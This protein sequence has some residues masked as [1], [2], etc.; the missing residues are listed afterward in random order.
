[1][2][3]A[4]GVNKFIIFKL[5]FS[6]L[7]TVQA[8]HGQTD[9]RFTQTLV[10]DQNIFRNYQ[11]ADDWIHQSMLLFEQKV[12]TNPLTFR[13]NYAGSLQ[14]FQNYTER[15][16][17]AHQLMGS[18][19]WTLTELLDLNSGLNFDWF[20]NRETYKIYDFTSLSFFS[21]LGI[22]FQQNLPVEIG[23]E[24]ENQNY[25]ALTQFSCL[26]QIGLMRLK[27]FL[28]TKTTFIGELNFNSK[29]YKNALE[30]D[31]FEFEHPGRRNRYGQS[32]GNGGSKWI[33]DSDSLMT[34][35]NLSV[36]NSTQWRLSVRLA[37]SIG[38]KTG[39]S[40]V[41]SHQFKPSNAARYLKEQIYSFSL[42]NS[43][44]DD[45][46]TYESTGYQIQIS[47]LLPAGSSLKVYYDFADK[48]YAYPTT[49]PLIIKNNNRH[50]TQESIHLD[51]KI[52]LFRTRLKN[53]MNLD[54]MY[55]YLVNVS[56]DDYFNYRGFVIE[57]GI[58]FVFK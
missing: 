42:N 24:I 57:T 7:I 10:Y 40:A 37:Q 52:P 5:L 12:I 41:Y 4:K 16:F 53:R 33:I 9:L 6:G 35:S 34:A 47:R 55:E 20:K 1:M 50:D 44:Y 51:Y 21:R 23:Y 31:E 17:Q 14:L 18:V 19:N 26:E 38:S 58:N 49:G 36:N 2:A 45:P 29:N 32:R 22:N 30:L 27:Y 15:H 39:L 43:L 25:P 54:F 46:F 13:F 11:Q 8:L 48:N 56:N 28:P 3:D